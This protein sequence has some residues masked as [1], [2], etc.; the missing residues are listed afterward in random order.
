MSRLLRPASEGTAAAYAYLSAV[1]AAFN[2]VSGGAVKEQE[3]VTRGLMFLTKL[4]KSGLAGAGGGV[5]DPR[6]LLFA[7]KVFREAP[8]QFGIVYPGFYGA[9]AAIAFELLCHHRRR[10]N[11]AA[12][13]LE[14]EEIFTHRG[15]PWEIRAQIIAAFSQAANAGWR[16][17]EFWDTTRTFLHACQ[18]AV[19]DK[20]DAHLVVEALVDFWYMLSLHFGKNHEDVR[21]EM[22]AVS[23]ALLELIG[24]AQAG[25]QALASWQY[26]LEEL[27]LPIADPKTKSVPPRDRAIQKTLDNLARRFR[28]LGQDHETRF[29]HAAIKEMS[30]TLMPYLHG[31]TK[32]G[33]RVSPQ[34][35]FQKCEAIIRYGDGEIKK[36]VDIADICARSGRGFRIE[37]ADLV[38]K[39]NYDAEYGLSGGFVDGRPI[40][41]VEAYIEKDGRAIKIWEVELIVRYPSNSSA[42]TTAQIPPI[43]TKVVRAWPLGQAKSGWALLASTDVQLPEDW[44]IYLR[45][46]NPARP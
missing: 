31:L 11:P 5:D 9:Y 10:I 37:V 30:P 14:F 46:L 3:E 27:K 16:D 26:A 25:S 39:A 42:G 7:L 15:T 40:R 43:S 21:D 24:D 45:Q 17:K 35:A 34:K 44:L 6:F 2:E 33:W 13:S 29:S 28:A 38:V 4:G 8:A 32:E 36:Q 22:I 20:V 1:R 19:S 18:E 23:L 12:I 41:A